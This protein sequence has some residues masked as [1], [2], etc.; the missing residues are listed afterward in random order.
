M[1]QYCHIG[2]IINV[3]SS[4]VI[5]LSDLII[6]MQSRR[7]DIPTPFVTNVNLHNIL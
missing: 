7:H 6:L 4:F 5:S 1:A 3:T 2:T